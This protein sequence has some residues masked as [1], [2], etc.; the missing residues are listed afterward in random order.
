[1]IN[2]ILTHYEHI[3]LVFLALLSLGAGRAAV[4][5]MRS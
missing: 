1:M 2:F 5:L 3:Q 4:T